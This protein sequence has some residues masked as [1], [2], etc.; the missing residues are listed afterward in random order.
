MNYREE[1]EL[2]QIHHNDFIQRFE[3]Q[4]PNA[5]W[6]DIEATIHR[7]LV[8]IFKSATAYEPPRG[9]GAYGKSRALYA[10]DL[11]LEW[12]RCP[13]EMGDSCKFIVKP[14]ICELNFIPDCTRACQ[15]YP[16]FHNEAF[17]FLFLDI[18]SQDIVQLC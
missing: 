10:A 18:E 17:D 12:R 4:Y 1:D 5:V 16:N 2:F 7:M 14:Q 3:S 15:Y 8:S 11:L 13:N 9:L 6:K